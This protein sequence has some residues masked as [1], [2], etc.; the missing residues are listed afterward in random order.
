MPAV[1]TRILYR[2]IGREIITPFLLGFAVFTFVL[3][4]GR[5]IKLA[6]M[7]IAKGVPLSDVLRL[8]VYM[9]PSFSI[10]TIPMSFLLAVLLAFGR[11]SADSELTAMKAT[12][13]SLYGLLPPVIAF[14]VIAYLTTTSIT[15]YALPWGNTAFK[16]L[17]YN[18]INTRVNISLKDR[19]FNDDFPGLVIYVARYDEEKHHISG[20]LIYDER[21]P[22]ETV[23][24]FAKNG[25]IMTDPDKKALRLRLLDG[26]VHRPRGKS[27]YQLMEFES[28]D[29]SV[30]FNQNYKIV[31]TINELDMTFRDLRKAMANPG[32]DARTTRDLFLEFHR[33]LA[34]PFACFVFALIGVPLGLQNRRAG[35]SSGFSICIALLLLYYILLTAGKTLGQKGV[36]SPA[37][38]M[39]L[40]NILFIGLGL[41]L[42]SKTANDQRIPVF[43]LPARLLQRAR[44]RLVRFRTQ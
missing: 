24:I 22:E 1:M 20:I 12:G 4:M 8:V 33:R 3:L 25:L 32:N 17:L 13:I 31:P 44:L 27:G 19:V 43:E 42:F 9:L 21:N 11:L 36:I 10:V 40:P 30:N 28:Y 6:E 5:F 26:G 15:V 18:A 23:T 16:T 39:W 2:Y 14:A 37:I 35:K 29:L 38:S 34:L 41:Y 7:V